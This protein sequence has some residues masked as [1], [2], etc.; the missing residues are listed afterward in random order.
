MSSNKY[1]KMA[2]L[3]EEDVSKLVKVECNEC[4]YG[5]QVILLNAEK[6]HEIAKS[7]FVCAYCVRDLSNYREDIELGKID[8]SFARSKKFFYRR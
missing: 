1:H 3:S 4:H 7:N 5:K 6:D 8:L 2:M